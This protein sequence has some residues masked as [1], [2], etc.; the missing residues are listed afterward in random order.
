MKIAF[1]STDGKIINRKFG[2]AN[3]FKIWEI[4]PDQAAYC[5]DRSAITSNLVADECNT[6]RANAVADCSIVCSID[7]GTGAL[8]KVVARKAFHL[9]TGTEKPI[10]E[11]VEKLQGVLRGNPPPWMKKAMGMTAI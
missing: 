3:D 4:G 7:I 11:I 5:G 9:K 1:A 10:M 2:E 8:A 6:A